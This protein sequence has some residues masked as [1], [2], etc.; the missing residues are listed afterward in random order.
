MPSYL[1]EAYA[2]GPA[3]AATAS[4]RSAAERVARQG[5]PVRLVL[6]IFVPEDETCFHVFEADSP[7]DVRAAGTLA[8][9]AV[10]RVVEAMVDAAQPHAGLALPELGHAPP[11]EA[12]A[13]LEQIV[14]DVESGAIVDGV[15]RFIPE[16]VEAYLRA[17]QRGKAERLQAVFEERASGCGYSWA[18]ATAARTRGLLAGEEDFAAAF[19][20]ALAQHEGTADTYERARTELCYG[21]RLRRARRRLEA[22]RPLRAALQTFEALGA[23]GWAERARAELA[24]SVE[25]ARRGDRADDEG[26]TPQERRVA[27]TVATGA[28]N[29]ETAAELFLSPKTIEFHL[30]HVY[31]KLGVRSRTELALRLKGSESPAAAV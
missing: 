30:G 20:D 18:L 8:G 27:L 28:S 25:T 13:R 17:G 4:A 24:A 10:D 11:V 19:Q 12:V 3:S 5:L 26:L 22:R 9:L 7:D 23:H 31:R 2:A 21:E 14:G 1:L 6:S 15:S 29:K 16:L